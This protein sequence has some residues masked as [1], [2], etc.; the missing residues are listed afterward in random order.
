M[1]TP[2]KRQAEGETEMG[3]SRGATPAPSTGSPGESQPLFADTLDLSPGS[4]SGGQTGRFPPGAVFSDRFE[5]LRPLGAGGSA[6]VYAVRDRISGLE[7]ALKLLSVPALARP[8]VQERLS[9]ELEATRRLSHPAIVRTFDVGVAEGY[10]YLTMELLRGSNL[11]EVLHAAGPIPAGLAVRIFRDI[12]G[13][14]G[15]AHQAGVIH[16]DIKPGNIVLEGIEPGQGTFN[17]ARLKIVDFGLAR[18]DEGG[19]LTASGMILGTPAY[20]SPEQV[21]GLPIGPASDLYAASIVLFE[22]LT[23]KVPFRAETPIATARLHLL[24]SRPRLEDFV[25]GIDL[26]LRH[27][28]QRGLALSTGSRWQN[29]REILSFLDDSSEAAARTA[30]GWSTALT[31]E[32]SARIPPEPSAVPVH[33]RRT[34]RWAIGAACAV[35]M[36]CAATYAWREWAFAVRVDTKEK[37]LVGWN[38]W[39]RRAWERRFSS[40]VNFAS[41]VRTEDGSS[42]W[43]VGTGDSWSAVPGAVPPGPASSEIQ[44]LDSL[45]HPVWRLPLLDGTRGYGGVIP[46]PGMSQHLNPQFSLPGEWGPTGSRALTVVANHIAWY[47]AVI[48]GIDQLGAPVS[49]VWHPG[50]FFNWNPPQKSGPLRGHQLAVAV[51]NLMGHRTAIVSIDLTFQQ[52][53]QLP[54]FAG[55]GLRAAVC[56]FYT[57][58]PGRC[59]NEQVSMEADGT[60]Q[61]H[62]SIGIGGRLDRFGNRL[63]YLSVHPK[64][65]PEAAAANSAEAIRKIGEAASLGQQERHA[66][67]VAV[68]DQLA[69]TMDV[70]PVWTSWAAYEAGR[71]SFQEGDLAGARRRFDLALSIDPQLADAWRRSGELAIVEG[72]SE[73]AHRDL[74]E[75]A[76]Q[77]GNNQAPEMLIAAAGIFDR[78]EWIHPV[79]GR[80]AVEA[81]YECVDAA[82][83]ALKGDFSGYQGYRQNFL[84]KHSPEMIVDLARSDLEMNRHLEEVPNLLEWAAPLAGDEKVDQLFPLHMKARLASLTEKLM[85]APAKLEAERETIAQLQNRSVRL[86]RELAW[87]DLDLARAFSVAGDPVRSTRFARAA[88][89]D[90][91]ADGYIR[92]EAGKLLAGN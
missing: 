15:A 8:E 24:A 87:A 10:L 68:L 40:R 7:C 6:E 36:A 30:A 51:N 83:G 58:L 47:P 92:K 61:V 53:A 16:R 48:L 9:R 79:T 38:R 20:L 69:V 80:R 39:N 13:G 12:L 43:V 25:T 11:A 85:D 34:G 65:S 71:I 60:I 14:L 88:I 64:L 18:L 29:A 52:E 62:S 73:R 17:Y 86:L 27:V 33:R 35:L 3:E 50:Y 56:D 31:V 5:I 49:A 54:P 59:R 28:I 2:D 72:N 74:L 41:P 37:T 76:R 70:D 44:R 91:G 55:R 84:T 26:R 77:D 63:E 21:S 1:K 90:R 57:L 89:A 66:E 19:S 81:L 78:P 75:G 23:G 67:A 32:T 4:N 42:G 22:M 82:A 46:Y 45:G